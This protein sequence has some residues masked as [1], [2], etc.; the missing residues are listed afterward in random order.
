MLGMCIFALTHK[1]INNLALCE[2]LKNPE[3]N[4]GSPNPTC[5]QFEN[6]WFPN[7]AGNESL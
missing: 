3:L 1:E 5:I 2:E 6:L 4:S 7:S